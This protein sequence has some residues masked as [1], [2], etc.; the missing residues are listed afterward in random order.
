MTDGKAPLTGPASPQSASGR[1]AAFPP[2]AILDQPEAGLRASLDAG[3]ESPGYPH[4]Q[5]HVPTA[6]PADRWRKR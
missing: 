1:P 3:G 4:K 2:P 6:G 5:R